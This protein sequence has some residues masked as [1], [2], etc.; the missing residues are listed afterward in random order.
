MNF[1]V[2]QGK[3]GALYGDSGAGK[4][5]I[6]RL[7]AGLIQPEKGHV[8]FLGN[9]WYDSSTKHHLSIKKR[10]L[11]FVFQ[12]NTLF[13]NMTVRRNLEYALSSKSELNKVDEIIALIELREIECSMPNELSGGQKQ[14]VALARSLVQD[15]ELLLLDEALSSL[16]QKSREQLQ[17]IILRI[18]R[19]L[20]LTI[21]LVSHDISEIVKM[22]A[23]VI[24]VVNGKVDQIGSPVEIFNT[25]TQL[26][27]LKL[28]GT[29]MS[30]E[31]VAEDN[32]ANVHF[33]SSHVQ[34]RIPKENAGLY[35]I[36]DKI[37]FSSNNFSSDISK[38][39]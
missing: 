5:S 28:E 24:K 22:A 36:G 12:E 3:I 39:S 20:N 27:Q 10:R 2:E 6:L 18:H 14:K 25:E 19:E 30:F 23:S 11:G 13:P 4:T 38:K 16:D 34:V 32:I 7:I 37:I 29:I 17:D 1:Q 15:P 8:S 21:L 9:I 31:K 26:V 35:K 33:D